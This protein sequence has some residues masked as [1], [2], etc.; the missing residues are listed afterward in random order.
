MKYDPAA[1]LLTIKQEA[2]SL[3]ELLAPC[4]MPDYAAI[5]LACEN[6]ADAAADIFSWADFQLEEE[7]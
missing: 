4:S 7:E 1:D 3:R 6:I 5:C 2:K